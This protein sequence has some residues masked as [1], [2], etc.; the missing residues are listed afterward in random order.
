MKEPEDFIFK[1]VI[2]ILIVIGLMLINMG[3]SIQTDSEIQRLETAIK[4]APLSCQ[5]II[6]KEVTR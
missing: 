3:I 2:I 6:N 5:R 1:T 4:S